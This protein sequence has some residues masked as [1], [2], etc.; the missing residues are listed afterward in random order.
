MV[1]PTR[2]RSWPGLLRQL[3][4][5]ADLDTQDATWAM[6]EVMSGLAT[7][8]QL[9]AFVV[10]LRIKGETPAEIAGLADGML[11]HSRRVHVAQRA[12]DVVG[13]GGDQAH[14]VNISTMAAL[15]TAA[16]GAPVIKHGN[17]AASSQCGA[18]DVLEALGVAIDLGP[19]QVARCVAEVGIGFCFAPAYHPAMRHAAAVRREIGIPTAF[20]FLGPLINP[21]QPGAALVGCADLRMAPVMAQVL[22][23]RGVSALVVRGDDGLDEITTTTTTSVWVVDGRAVRLDQ[24]D[25][26]ALSVPVAGVEEL[27]GGDAAVNADAVRRLLAGDAGPVRDAVLLNAGAALVAHRGPTG[28]LVAD[29]REMIQRAAEAVDSGAAAAML[30]RWTELTTELSTTVR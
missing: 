14:T 27:R 20:N 16:A 1:A 22:A 7:P 13:T 11:S 18:A 30:T 12:I 15:V 26:A 3:I 21:A 25:P 28:D 5:G 9:A 10:A 19:E 23:D 24:L 17:R 29:I 4:A 8:A 6:D 2:S